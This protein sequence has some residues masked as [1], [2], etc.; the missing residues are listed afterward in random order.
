MKKNKRN[1]PGLKNS[2]SSN[3]EKNVLP[4]L[5]VLPPAALL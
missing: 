3:K 4:L 1:L 2:P 5:V